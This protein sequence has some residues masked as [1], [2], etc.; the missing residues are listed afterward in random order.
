MSCVP[1]SVLVFAIGL[2]LW[3]ADWAQAQTLIR[4]N[5]RIAIIGNT[6]VERARHG[7]HLETAIQLAAGPKTTGLVFRNLGWSGDTVFG[8][9]RSY[10]GPPSEGRDR[11]DKIVA[12]IEPTIVVF[13]YGTGAAT[14]AGLSWTDEP[15]AA[16][17]PEVG[18]E[19]SLKAFAEG[20]QSMVD[21]VGKSAGGNLRQLVF[22]APPPLENLGLPFPD[23]TSNNQRMKAYRD[24][25]RELA[26][27]ND[28][29]FVDLF[30]ALG[31]DD[32]RSDAT[33]SPLTQNGIHHN[34]SGYRVIAREL[35]KGFGYMPAQFAEFDSGSSD[36][37]RKLVIE[38]NRLFFNRWRPSNETYLFL[39]RAHEQGKNAKEVTLLDPIIAD[40]EQKIEQARMQIFSQRTDN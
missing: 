37:L 35:A 16:S 26:E 25:I 33:G 1:F 22:V 4:S 31:G 13:C 2:L 30:S 29:V 3:P 34:D 32:H 7:G 39:F 17:A 11:L 36:D 20:Y 6:L 24:T 12:E 8:D 40:H 19:T 27:K 28:G 38:K 9:A 21:R 15:N 5:D 14:S 23:Q 10:F 18:L